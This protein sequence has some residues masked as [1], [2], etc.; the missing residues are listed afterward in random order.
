MI[1]TCPWCG[2]THP[3]WGLIG[4]LA[5]EGVLC[6]ACGRWCVLEAS[7]VYPRLVPVRAKAAQRDAFRA[8]PIGSLLRDKFLKSAPGRRTRRAS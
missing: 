2:K 7:D 8:H 6:M 3:G 5:G 4:Y 1:G